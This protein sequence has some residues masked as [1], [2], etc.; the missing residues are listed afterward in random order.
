M[1]CPRGDIPSQAGRP[2]CLRPLLKA[3]LTWS[4]ACQSEAPIRKHPER[5][6]RKPEIS[7]ARKI[8]T[9]Q[10]MRNRLLPSC[11]P[12]R[13]SPGEGRHFHAAKSISSGPGS[14]GS[15]PG[16]SPAMAG[17]MIP[18]GHVILKKVIPDKGKQKKVQG[19]RQT[20]EEAFGEDEA[21]KKAFELLGVGGTFPGLELSAPSRKRFLGFGKRPD[22]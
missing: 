10:R 9:F 14:G 17:T 21:R 3:L 13:H 22:T 16:R 19:I 20:M 4:V 1:I 12:R 18:Y 7:W 5:G 8:L 15:N 6:E 2:L 11:F